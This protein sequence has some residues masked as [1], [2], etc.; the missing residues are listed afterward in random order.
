[1]STKAPK[2]VMFVTIPGK[3]IPS[4]RSSTSFTF[5]SNSKTSTCSLGS[6]P[7]FSSSFMISVSVGIPTSSVTY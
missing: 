7:G 5:G 2:L 4:S 6:L 3:I 1:M